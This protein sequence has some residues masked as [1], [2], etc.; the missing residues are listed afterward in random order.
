MRHPES[1]AIPLSQSILASRA[2][3]GHR[4]DSDARDDEVGR[5]L[6]P[7]GKLDGAERAAVA[8]AADAGDGGAEPEIHAAAR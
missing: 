7:V 4:L 3:V 8:F 1:T 2:R 6:G 5:D